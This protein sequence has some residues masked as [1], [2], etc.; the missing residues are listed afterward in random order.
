M[1]VEFEPLEPV[2]TCVMEENKEV[3]EGELGE[4]S[5][6][7]AGGFRA[8]AVREDMVQETAV[9]CSRKWKQQR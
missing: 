4:I 7:L 2:E 8:R 1:T 6:F 9:T 3:M 5:F